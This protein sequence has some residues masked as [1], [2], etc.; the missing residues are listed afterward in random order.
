M[1]FTLLEVKLVKTRSILLALILI[2][3][4]AICLAQGGR[5]VSIEN[6]GGWNLDAD[7][8]MVNTP[9]GHGS[10]LVSCYFNETYESAA[11]NIAVYLEYDD[12]W[13]GPIP[14]VNQDSWRLEFENLTGIEFCFPLTWDGSDGRYEY[15]LW[16]P[17]DSANSSTGIYTI[18]RA[19]AA[20]GHGTCS[21]KLVY[22]GGSEYAFGDMHAISPDINGDGVVNVSDTA[23]FASLYSSGTYHKE[24]DFV[25]NGAIELSDVAYYTAAY[26]EQCP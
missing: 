19:L 6:Q 18:S 5:P 25:Y 1:D 17:F 20:G 3:L 4:P 14:H 8:L 21:V 9:E 13:P 11:G 16:G 12:A 10:Q 24:I 2:T 23:D 22:T 26:G 15:W 7:I